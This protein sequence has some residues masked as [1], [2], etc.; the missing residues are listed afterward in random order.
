MHTTSTFL[1]STCIKIVDIS[2]ITNMSIFNTGLEGHMPRVGTL[3]GYIA[4]STIKENGLSNVFTILK[5]FN[6]DI[7]FSLCMKAVLESV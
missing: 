6:G 3:F 1:L 7:G 2:P 5:S 4:K